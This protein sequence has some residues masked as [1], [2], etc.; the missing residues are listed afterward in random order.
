MTPALVL[1][2]YGGPDDGDGAQLD[3]PAV[4]PLR[5]ATPLGVYLRDARLDLV[6]ADGTA[7]HRY[8]WQ[9]ATSPPPE[10]ED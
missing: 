1:Q 10:L 3:G 4:L 9:P 6:R 8:R 5:I 2:L 7:V